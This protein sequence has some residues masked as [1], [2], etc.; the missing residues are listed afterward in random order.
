MIYFSIVTALL[1][2]LCFVLLLL[3]FKAYGKFRQRKW[4][5]A[6][7]YFIPT[8]LALAIFVISA[9]FLAPRCFDLIDIARGHYEVRTV[10]VSSLEF[11]QVLVTA[12]DERYYYS[13]AENDVQS[14]K[15]YQLYLAPR[16]QF[17]DR[18]LLIE[19]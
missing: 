18:L 5:K 12:E 16:T 10:E 4:T 14:D 19:R 8:V 9:F 11:P 13:R 15:T 6:R 1:F 2:I 7:Q 17:A 3:F